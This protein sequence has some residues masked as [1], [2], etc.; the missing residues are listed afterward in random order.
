MTLINLVSM[1]NLSDIQ[2]M[3]CRDKSTGDGIAVGQA[4]SVEEL[5]LLLKA[6]L[7]I[8]YRHLFC[9]LSSNIGP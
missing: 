8:K 3:R 9:E 2:V 7:I 5:Q 1:R 6:S 4:G